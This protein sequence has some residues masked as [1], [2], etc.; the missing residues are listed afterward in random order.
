MD[1]QAFNPDWANKTTLHPIGLI[2]VVLLAIM[3]L[4]LHY[5]YIIIA[6]IVLQIINPVS[7]WR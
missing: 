3:I 1:E 2:T 7:C 4:L 6:I 5:R